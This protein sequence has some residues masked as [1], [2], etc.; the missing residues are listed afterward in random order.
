MFVL[1]ALILLINSTA[2]YALIRDVIKTNTAY[3]AEHYIGSLNN[4]LNSYYR[5]TELIIRSLSL[6]H[7]D[8][9]E[10]LSIE[11]TRSQ[12]QQFLR[13][14]RDNYD[15][16]DEIVI[17]SND[18]DA[19]ATS[20]MRIDQLLRSDIY[21]QLIGST[22]ELVTTPIVYAPIFENAIDERGT[23]MLAG[24]KIIP[25]G[26]ASVRAD[27]FIIVSLKVDRITAIIEQREK[28]YDERLVL[29]DRKGILMEPASSGELPHNGGEML[30][31]IGKGAAASYSRSGHLVVSGN[32]P[33]KQPLNIV[34]IIPEEGLLKDA[35]ILFKLQL[36]LN[37]VLLLVGMILAF[38]LAYYILNPV[39]RLAKFMDRTGDLGAERL[40]KYPV[41]QKMIKQRPKD[42]INRLISS[43]NR[44]IDRL[45][46]A[47]KR[48]DEERLKQKKAEVQA[49][50]AQINPHFIY[51]TLNNIRWLARMG[52]A[53]LVFE[54]ITS[55]NVILVS[56]FQLERP[57]IAISEELKQLEA[58]VAIQKQVYLNKF[59][60]IYEIDDQ[61]KQ[62]MIPR[63]S[64]QPLVENAIFHGILPKQ[65]YGIIRIKGWR[66][67]DKL[68]LQ[69]IDNGVG[70]EQKMRTSN[71]KKD[72]DKLRDLDKDVDRERIEDDLI[73]EHIGMSNV[74]K[75]IKLYF[76]EDYGVNW[77]SK[78]GEGMIVTVVLPYE[79]RH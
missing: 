57:L 73:R 65:E 24:I 28:R 68:Y 51:N 66:E 79:R 39:A 54:M 34:G 15:Y 44:M 4:E 59:N 23:L 41:K 16:V 45:Q 74:G 46:E 38:V 67:H 43:F 77:Q 37:F 18:L 6:M 30:L 32:D 35:S 70:Y 49:L 3:Y 75:R 13:S 78:T 56:A 11:K 48:V 1:N 72:E 47:A 55:V 52:N 31:D 69:I 40:T 64:L 12:K 50:Q 8:L 26:A 53:D 2:G 17:M 63:M 60:V 58:Y 7:P 29:V 36:A 76:G 21:R 20:S 62:G 42:E 27:G 61:V 10:G 5:E 19:V 14:I 25:E 22:G 71:E 9:F 33:N